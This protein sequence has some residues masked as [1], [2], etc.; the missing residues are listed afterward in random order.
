MG[1]P[2][3][4]TRHFQIRGTSGYI[5]LGRNEI[6]SRGLR[7]VACRIA[8]LFWGGHRRNRHN[9]YIA[10]FQQPIQKSPKSAFTACN[11][12]LRSSSSGSAAGRADIILAILAAS[13]LSGNDGR[14]RIGCWIRCNITV[15]TVSPKPLQ[16]TDSCSASDSTRIHPIV[17]HTRQSVS[18][19][20]NYHV[21]QWDTL[22]EGWCDWLSRR[23][24]HPHF[25]RVIYRGPPASSIL[26]SSSSCGVF[27]RQGLHLLFPT[28]PLLYIVSSLFSSRRWESVCWRHWP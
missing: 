10:Q 5:L 22:G 12:R 15:I 25:P 23:F 3:L 18:L 26:F 20:R 16:K 17:G 1:I 24:S 6:C 8:V 27:V 21:N 28:H 4:E 9:N 11:T 14:F 13:V 19:G 7:T 2:Q